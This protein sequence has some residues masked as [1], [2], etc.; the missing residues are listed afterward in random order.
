MPEAARE[1]MRDAM[2]QATEAWREAAGRGPD[3]RAALETAC[4]A[5]RDAAA[6]ATRAMGCAW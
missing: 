6:E 3:M 4:T 5:A 1:T 2:R